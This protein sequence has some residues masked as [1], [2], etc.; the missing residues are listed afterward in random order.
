MASLARE[1]FGSGGT[2]N[3]YAIDGHDDILLRVPEQDLDACRKALEADRMPFKWVDWPES[4]RRDR[5]LGV[6]LAM[7]NGEEQDSGAGEGDNRVK[8]ADL[9]GSQ[10]TP[11]L[12]LLRKVEGRQPVE[13][14]MKPAASM[15]NVRNHGSCG[16]GFD[17]YTYYSGQLDEAT[18]LLAARYILERL[19]AGEPF[20]LT[21]SEASEGGFD[22][23]GGLTDIK[24]TDY[25]A[26]QADDPDLAGIPYRPT[27][28]GPVFYKAYEEFSQ[29]Y[30]RKVEAIARMPQEAFD[31]AFQLIVES[32]EEHGIQLDFEH[33][34]NML[35]DADRGEFCFVDIFPL[36][37]GRGTE[38]S[39]EELLQGFGECLFGKGLLKQFGGPHRMIHLEQDL[40]RFR[41]ARNIILAK[42]DKAS[43]GLREELES[44]YLSYRR[45]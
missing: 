10:G 22:V 9:N 6:A 39:T 44:G 16:V 45:T 25:G 28:P 11:A 17:L 21:K 3:V 19:K 13:N 15:V 37:Q 42:L 33:Q 29:F 5:R 31:G 38:K 23:P 4:V 12:W 40:G 35:V 1:S 43:P 30:L 41:A 2:A 18:G 27:N 36:C 34:A 24:T 26:Y 8:F 20:Q 32:I 7:A 14:S